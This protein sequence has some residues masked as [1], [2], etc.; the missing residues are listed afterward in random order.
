MAGRRREDLC[1]E[2]PVNQTLGNLESCGVWTQGCELALSMFWHKC[3][4]I[5]PIRMNHGFAE[6]AAGKNEGYLPPHC[7]TS[8]DD[9]A[10]GNKFNLACWESRKDYPPL[11]C[12]SIWGCHWVWWH[13]E[14]HEAWCRTRVRAE[15]KVQMENSREVPH[16]SLNTHFPWSWFAF[17][18]PLS[19]DLT[20]SLPY[21]LPPSPRRASTWGWGWGSGWLCFPMVFSWVEIL[22][23]TALLF[24]PYF[25][26]PLPW[27]SHRL[28]S[29]CA[30]FLCS[31]VSFLPV[32]AKDS[33]VNVCYFSH[34]PRKFLSSQTN[35][36][37]KPLQSFMLKT[38]S[39]LNFGIPKHTSSYISLLPEFW[40]DFLLG[41]F[42]SPFPGFG[43]LATI[44]I[45]FLPLS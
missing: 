3:L 27:L 43:F 24:T 35:V 25:L 22:V 33:L 1:C 19:L 44:F 31:I 13:L 4:A 21:L 2:Q 28:L 14:V 41:S 6:G 8:L 38:L 40:L 17:S 7:H 11:Y 5:T 9:R 10:G 30:P 15:S 36:L 37:M 29:I 32:T 20:S 34:L 26:P 39:P 45:A 42:S 12:F 18:L 16:P 23:Y